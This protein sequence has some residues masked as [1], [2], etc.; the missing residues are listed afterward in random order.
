E[1]L[2]AQY[3][4]DGTI[5]FDNTGLKGEAHD[6]AKGVL[7]TGGVAGLVR[8]NVAQPNEE[9]AYREYLP[10]C[11]HIIYAIGYERNKLPSIIINNNQDVSQFIKHDPKNGRLLTANLNPLPGLYGFGIAFPELVYDPRVGPEESVGMMK[12]MRYITSVL[13][14]HIYDI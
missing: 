5:L 11:S 10:Q 14:Q 2:Y 4:E 12:F 1:L 3:L 6:W 9:K 8:V 7:E 13:P